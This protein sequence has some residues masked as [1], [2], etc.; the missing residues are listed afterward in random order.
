MA[1][2]RAAER[3]FLWGC[4]QAV[5]KVFPSVVAEAAL[6]ALR[7]V[8]RRAFDKVALMAG[9]KVSEMVSD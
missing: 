1:E 9:S 8:A 3:V 7:T 6:W 5:K 2:N 4:E